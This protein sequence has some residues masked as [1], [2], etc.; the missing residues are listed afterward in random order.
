MDKWEIKKNNQNSYMISKDELIFK[1]QVGLAGIVDCNKKIEG[2]KK[3]PAG[4]WNIKTIFYRP[5]R[6]DLAE[7]IFRSIMP[8]KKIT[9]N[10][11]WCDDQ[12][13]KKYNQ[14]IKIK[15]KGL[16]FPFNY[17]KLWRDDHVYDI[18]IELDY[19]DHPVILNKGS[20]I[21]IHCS[22]T[23]YRPTNGCIAVHN[24]NLI[25]LVKNIKAETKIIIN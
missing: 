17:E 23:D 16:S 2:D 7:I 10:C 8:F 18:F 1:C 12:K 19:N 13:S 9:K 25:E 15:D 5:D 14:Y 3:T 22:F 24:E 11:G 21:F 6:I 4:E 20:A